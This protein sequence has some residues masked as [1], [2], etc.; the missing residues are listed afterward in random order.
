VARLI[1][2]CFLEHFPYRQLHMWWRLKGT[3]QYLRGNVK[4]EPMRRVGFQR[5]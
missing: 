3:I 5:Q 4:W 2:F 1:L